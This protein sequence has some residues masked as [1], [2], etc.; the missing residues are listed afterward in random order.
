MGYS[1][2]L[3]AIAKVKGFLQ[4]I[5]DTKEN[6]VAWKSDNP[7]KLQYQIHCGLSSAKKLE[8]ERFKH[9]KDL[10]KIKIKENLVIVEKKAELTIPS[11]AL[12]FEDIPDIYG[13]ITKATQYKNSEEE[14]LFTNIILA[15]DE[16]VKLKMWCD[17]YDYVYRYDP[18][19]TLQLM[20][21]G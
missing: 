1:T 6:M 16:L 12:I 17:N 15:E 18:A 19:N 10:W 14:L 9:L 11:A 4:T 2:S 13:V 21:V 5:K 3:D 7:K 8:D 20:K